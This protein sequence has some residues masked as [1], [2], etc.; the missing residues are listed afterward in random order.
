VPYERIVHVEVPVERIVYRDVPVPVQSGD[1]RVVTKEIQVPVEVVREVP[2][3]VEHIVYKEVQVPVEVGMRQE[4]R[5][6]DQRTVISTETRRG[7]ELT[8]EH[9]RH[10]LDVASYNAENK[11]N[12]YAGAQAGDYSPTLTRTSPS[13][14]RSVAP[15]RMLK[16]KRAVV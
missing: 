11:V 13:V 7:S 8:P 4:T 10:H 12:A 14:Q 2:V 9:K 15:V 6:L 3:P 5:V 1:E 16:R